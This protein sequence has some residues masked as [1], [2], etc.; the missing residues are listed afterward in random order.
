VRNL[1]R[2]LQPGCR[3]RS[4]EHC[5]LGCLKKHAW[6]QEP[7]LASQQEGGGVAGGGTGAYKADLNWLQERACLKPRVKR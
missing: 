7:F 5:V 2:P 1:S 4:R 3:E 6:P